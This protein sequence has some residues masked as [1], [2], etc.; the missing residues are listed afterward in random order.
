MNLPDST[1]LALGALPEL[2][3]VTIGLGLL[4]L[5]LLFIFFMIWNAFQLWM[6]SILSNAP[7]GL[8]SIVLMRFRKVDAN[9]I[10][11]ARITAKKAGIDISADKLEGHYMARGHVVR[12]IQALIA[13]SKADIPL[14]FD[15]AC[16]IDL[17]GRDVLDAVQTSVNPKVI[18]VPTPGQSPTTIDGVA[19]NGI[20]L[21]VK[22]RV[23]VRTNLDR[24]VGGATENT[25]VARVG[26]GIVSTIGAAKNHMEVLENPKS[27]SKTV[28]D[29]A[30]DA[31]TAFQILS[32]DIADVIVGENIGARLQTDQAEAQKIIAQAEAE[33]RRAMAVARE[34]EMIALVAENRAKVVLAEAEIPMAIA[35]A[36][37]NGRLG[38]M[39][40][41]NLRN[42]QADTEMRSS[43]ANP[44]AANKPEKPK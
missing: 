9:I 42:V 17:A 20:Q 12:V 22:A 6:Q 7:V 8:M 1:P 44:D 36:F 23:T 18:D 34:Q 14:T 43:I 27:I 5:M 35:D 11:T 38:V 32:I 15:R 25:I 28:L 2:N 37:R 39:D 10:V 19:G 30:L 26:Q 4:G 33:Q 3:P 16:A 21:K 31:G 24:L 40:Y 41:Y 13:A 29:S